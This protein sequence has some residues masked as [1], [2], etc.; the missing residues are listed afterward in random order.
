MKN[1]APAVSA[2]VLT[3]KWWKGSSSSACASS[4]ISVKR[5]T[6]MAGIICRMIPAKPMAAKVFSSIIAMRT[7]ELF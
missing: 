5:Y 1:D 3:K 7:G 6:S 4:A 2:R